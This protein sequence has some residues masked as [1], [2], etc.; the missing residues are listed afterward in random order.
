MAPLSWSIDITST[1][2][3]SELQRVTV[4]NRAICY[5]ND[6]VK[7]RTRAR[8]YADN[9]SPLNE[10]VADQ[11]RQ[12]VEEK[13]LGFPVDPALRADYAIVDAEE[14]IP[15][16]NESTFA[17]G[18][19]PLSLRALCSLGDV[20]DGLPD[21]DGDLYMADASGEA[22]EISNEYLSSTP[23]PESSTSTFPEPRNLPYDSRDLVERVRDLTCPHRPQ[24]AQTNFFPRELEQYL[25]EIDGI[26][27]THEPK[28]VP[29][30]VPNDSDLCSQSESSESTQDT[31][32]Y[33]EV[34]YVKP[35][36]EVPCRPRDPKYSQF[37]ITPRHLAQLELCVIE[38]DN[39]CECLR[40]HH[41]VVKHHTDARVDVWNNAPNP[42][43]ITQIMLSQGQSSRLRESISVDEKWPNQ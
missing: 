24:R 13:R 9:E 23:E 30:D 27:A 43:D 19:G 22:S 26:R 7:L 41:R 3:A 1:T 35:G 16:D 10:L 11:R 18:A 15:P 32:V 25:N 38:L 12:L 42:K 4:Y 34:F 29:V 33:R 31:D 5:I 40:A 20:I 36:E 21:N 28:E 39:A 14:Q 17:S 2:K 6:L 8:E 37:P